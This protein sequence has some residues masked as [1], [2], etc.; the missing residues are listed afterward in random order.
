MDADEFKIGSGSLTLN[1]E[2]IGG[3]TE[4]GVVVNYEPEVYL[5]KS[6]KYGSTPIKASLIGMQLTLEVAI[7]ETTK[8]NMEHVFAGVTSVGSKRQFGGVA[9]REIVGVP[10]VLTPFDGSPSWHFRNVVPTGSIEVAY[11]PDNP[12]VFKVT[13]TAL[14][15]ADATEAEN[16]AY[17]S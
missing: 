12:R 6:G 3:T 7:G 13:L 11:Q 2:D 9:G 16:V 8:E 5:H 15:D 17:V 1:G 14:V 10:L 4:E